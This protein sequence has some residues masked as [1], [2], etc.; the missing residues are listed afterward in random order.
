M[1]EMCGVAPAVIGTVMRCQEFNLSIVLAGPEKF[2]N[3][4]R[5]FADM[6]DDMDAADFAE[7][8]IRDRPGF[9][10]E[11]MDQVNTLAGLMVHSEPLVLFFTSAPE[12]KEWTVGDLFFH[13]KN[14]ARDGL[15]VNLLSGARMLTYSFSLSTIN[16]SMEKIEFVTDR[17]IYEQ[18]IQKAIPSAQKFVWIGTSDMKDLYVQRARGMRPFLAVLAELV[19]DGVQ[20]RLI[21]AKEPGPRFRKDFDRYPVLIDGL[22]RLH[23]PR[24]H[25]KSV[26]V[27]GI[28]AYTGSAN[29]TGAGMGAKSV[30]NRNFESG[31]ITTDKAL[32]GQIMGQF[33]HIWMGADC[34]KCG[35]RAFCTEYTDMA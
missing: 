20:L 18:V 14:I 8:R 23:C 13:G 22:E 3:Q 4:Y 12:I 33:D 7:A 24:I 35:R 10:I 5:Q 6:F 21:H 31:I 26:I 25:F 16:V 30:K 29:L 1:P 11:I 28:W 2:M 27:D 15:K 32:V 17:Q 9:F 34:N 19:K